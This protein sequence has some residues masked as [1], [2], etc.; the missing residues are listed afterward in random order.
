MFRHIIHQE[1][2]Q[3]MSESPGSV[4]LQARSLML[5]PEPDETGL[6]ESGTLWDIGF[7]NN[8]GQE[9]VKTFCL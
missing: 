8:E 1:D 2:I 7:I 6:E 3:L 5:C 9:M 4:N